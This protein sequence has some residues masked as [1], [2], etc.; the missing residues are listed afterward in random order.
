VF[1]SSK[2]VSLSL[3]LRSPV[4]AL[5]KTCV[6]G[7]VLSVTRILRAALTKFRVYVYAYGYNSAESQPI[8][9]KF[10]ALW[11]HC[12]MIVGAGRGRF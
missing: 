8:W 7:L 3:H 10:G 2:K 12:P 5:I 4:I 9:I 1:K 6:A 11:V